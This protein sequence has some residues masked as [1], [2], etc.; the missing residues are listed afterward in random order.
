MSNS[1][2]LGQSEVFWSA[3]EAIGTILAFFLA[4]IL[5]LYAIFQN[6]ILQPNI[7][8]SNC[9]LEFLTQSP[10]GGSSIHI[11][12][13]IN[14][15]SKLHFFGKSASNIKTVWWLKKDIKEDW[16]LQAFFNLYPIYLK[17][18]IGSKIITLRV[19]H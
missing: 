5:S 4:F 8:A 3:L 11:S 16:V 6:K 9:K 10:H 7:K 12:W 1:T 17:M 18:E 13:R 2:F 15:V 19:I 14:N